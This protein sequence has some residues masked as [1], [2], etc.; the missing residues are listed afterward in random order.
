[1][2]SGFVFSQALIGL[3]GAIAFTLAI[4]STCDPGEQMIFSTTLLIVFFTVWVQGGGTT[5]MLTW[6]DIK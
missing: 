5:Q 6:L 4:R 1:M 3:R 2:F